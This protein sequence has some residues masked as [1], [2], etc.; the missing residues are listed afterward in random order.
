VTIEARIARRRV[1]TYHRAIDAEGLPS[2]VQ[3][4]IV[5]VVLRGNLLVPTA[6]AQLD[7]LRRAVARTRN[8]HTST[9]LCSRSLLSVHAGLSLLLL[10]CERYQRSARN[11][12]LPSE[13][14]AR[15]TE[16]LGVAAG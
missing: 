1:D 6:V 9:D 11:G 5:D 10:E 16:A 15:R 7:R 4:G 3:E 2:H 12:P 14:G 8:A 13:P